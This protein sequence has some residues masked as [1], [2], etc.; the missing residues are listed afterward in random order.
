MRWHRLPKWRVTCSVVSAGFV[1]LV[2]VVQQYLLIRVRKKVRDFCH[3][4]QLLGGVGQG[5]WIY[6]RAF[7]ASLLRLVM[8]SSTTAVVRDVGAATAR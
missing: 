5:G 3:D 7:S 2:V 1:L 6:R 4:D 8:V